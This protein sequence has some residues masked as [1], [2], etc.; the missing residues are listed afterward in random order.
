M[1]EPTDPMKPIQILYRDLR[2]RGLSKIEVRYLLRS[3][4]SRTTQE[5]LQLIKDV[6]MKK[7]WLNQLK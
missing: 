3:P 7:L 1:A 6:R 2:K 4:L 5:S